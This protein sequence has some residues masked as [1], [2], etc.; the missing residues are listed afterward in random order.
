MDLRHSAPLVLGHRRFSLVVAARFSV[1]EGLLHVLEQRGVLTTFSLREAGLRVEERAYL[2]PE[3]EF[4][5]SL[6]RGER[7]QFGGDRAQAMRFLLRGRIIPVEVGG[8]GRVG[9]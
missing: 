8:D 3:G 6:R 2:H 5:I 9:R 4:S 1:A 7:P